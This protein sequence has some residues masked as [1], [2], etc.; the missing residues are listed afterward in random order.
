MS[1][2]NARKEIIEKLE[3]DIRY[4][5]DLAKEYGA[6]HIG[7]WPPPPG[8]VTYGERAEAHKE[9]LAVFQATWQRTTTE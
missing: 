9:A 4:Y 8:A 5:S 1:I 7:C 2:E 3:R 6:D